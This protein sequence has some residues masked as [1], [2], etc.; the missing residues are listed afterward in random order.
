MGFTEG[1]SNFE[2]TFKVKRVPG[3]EHKDQRIPCAHLVSI[4]GDTHSLCKQLQ[5]NS[6]KAWLHPA[7]SQTCTKATA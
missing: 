7:L 1:D 4:P 2:P 3:T 6:C 5:N